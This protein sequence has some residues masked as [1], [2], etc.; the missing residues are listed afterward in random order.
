MQQPG[1]S[2]CFISLRDAG[3]I[4]LVPLPYYRML[5]SSPCY[6]SSVTPL[7]QDMEFVTNLEE[8]KIKV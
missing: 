2:A 1:W 4:F 7:L 8:Y 3:F 6:P 5:R